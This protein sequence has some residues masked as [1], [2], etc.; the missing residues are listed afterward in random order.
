MKTNL[1]RFHVLKTSSLLSGILLTFHLA[2]AQCDPAPS[3]IVAWWPGEGDANDIV[4]TNN[5]TIAGGVVYASGQVGK[6]FQFSGT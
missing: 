5:G 1:M 2:F 3:G 4:G 6:A